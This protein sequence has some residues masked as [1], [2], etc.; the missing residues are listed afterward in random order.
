MNGEPQ[1]GRRTGILLATIAFL[2]GLILQPA[3]G[4]ITDPILDDPSRLIIAVSL[5]TICSLLAIINAIIAFRRD[6]NRRSK[7]IMALLEIISRRGGLRGE[8]INYRNTEDPDPYTFAARLFD[9]AEKEILIL[10]HRPSE[11]TER[12]GPALTLE[13]V[14]RKNYYDILTS[15]VTRRNSNGHYLRYRRIIQLKD[16]PTTEWECSPTNDKVFE[17][18]CREILRV[19]KSDKQYPSAIKTSS[20]FLPKMTITI[21]DAR[22][23]IMELAIE[24]EEPGG[25]TRIEGDLILVDEEGMLTRSLCQIFEYID[26]QASSLRRLR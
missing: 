15:R 25:S 23:V 20:I 11:G 21:I 8:F 26:S 22:I 13:S 16:G 6:D 19:Q 5:I 9:R 18:H 4:K 2:V 7:E 1:P 12:Y 3:L 10:D 14:K 17:S 24:G